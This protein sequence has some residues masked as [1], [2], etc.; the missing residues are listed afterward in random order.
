MAASPPTDETSIPR[1]RTPSGAPLASAFV[2]GALVGLYGGWSL[3]WLSALITGSVLLYALVANIRTETEQRHRT[4][5]VVYIV[6]AGAAFA[7]FGIAGIETGIPPAGIA[8]FSSW[9]LVALVVLTPLVAAFSVSGT[10]PGNPTNQE[11][12][13]GC[14]LLAWLG[15]ALH[16]ALPAAIF[17]GGLTDAM[18]REGV[19]CLLSVA[20]LAGLPVSAILGM[21]GGA[22]HARLVRAAESE[23]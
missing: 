1:V 18:D 14:G 2:I 5:A 23:A 13:A 6:G 3:T 12:G 15:I 8:S 11:L 16:Q 19:S 22:L 20:F 21:L 17:Y 10:R 7:V 4:R 9:L